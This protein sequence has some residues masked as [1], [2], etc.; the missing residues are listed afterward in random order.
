MILQHLLVKAWLLLFHLVVLQ[1]TLDD[2]IIAPLGLGPSIYHDGLRL[3]LAILFLIH[4]PQVEVDDREL[5]H[6]AL[7]LLLILEILPRDRFLDL[8][9]SR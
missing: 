2:G 6:R 4:L 5:Y 7:I 1:A 9:F 3:L 8:L